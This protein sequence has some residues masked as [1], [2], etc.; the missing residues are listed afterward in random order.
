RYFLWR[1]YKTDR[2]G[3]VCPY[4]AHPEIR[5]EPFSPCRG[6][7]SCLDGNGVTLF[8][9]LVFFLFFT[10]RKIKP[11]DQIACCADS[12][13]ARGAGDDCHPQ[14][15]F[16]SRSQYWLDAFAKF[17]RSISDLHPQRTAAYGQVPRFLRPA[18]DE[19]FREGSL[20]RDKRSVQPGVFGLVVVTV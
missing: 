11:A 12:L 7:I 9:K 17:F 4:S 2:C 3:A 5:V 20:L 19:N 14:S 15:H 8:Y 16:L 10:L 18:R 6:F 1:A 13:F